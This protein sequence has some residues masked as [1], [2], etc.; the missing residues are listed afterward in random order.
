MSLGLAGTAF[1]LFVAG[2]GQRVEAFGVP[3]VFVAAC[4]ALSVGFSRRMG[5][6]EN[7]S[8]AP[9]RVTGPES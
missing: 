1:A 7:L 9:A 3:S 2:S 4:A 5:H 6:V 8:A